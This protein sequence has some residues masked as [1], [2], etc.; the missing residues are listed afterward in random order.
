[1]FIENI[2][3]ASDWQRRSLSCGLLQTSQSTSVAVAPI[4]MCEE[5]EEE[6]EAS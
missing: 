5:Q 4:V 3:L 2:C 6:A 1:M